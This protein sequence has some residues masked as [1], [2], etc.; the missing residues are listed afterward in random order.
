[1]RR[2]LIAGGSADPQVAHLIRAAEALGVPHRALRVGPDTAPRISWDLGA[3]TLTL[4]GEPL[5]PGALFLRYDVFLADAPNPANARYRAE[6]WHGLLSAW[7]GAHPQVRWFNRG[8]RS[9][10][11]P[12]TLLLARA[13][14]LA[15]PETVISSDGAL[16]NDRSM[17][18]WVAKPVTGGGHCRPLV[19]LLA[20]SELR[21]G[22]S[23]APAMAQPRLPGPDMRIFGV[24]LR[25]LGFLLRSDQLDYRLDPRA[26]VEA[27]DEI[28]PEIARGLRG[29]AAELGIDFYAADLKRDPDGVWR[30]LEI[31]NQPM[32]AAFDAACDGALC[33]AMLEALRPGAG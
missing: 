22:A 8:S 16:L 31:N 28:P 10:S 14:G 6:A 32:F 18:G 33:A 13:H 2:L 19:E 27:L 7:A 11:K 1:M 15:V 5:S 9:R 30:Y 24:G 26:R 4:D 17:L 20:E 3:D 12:E 21:Q 25:Q 23:A 29:L